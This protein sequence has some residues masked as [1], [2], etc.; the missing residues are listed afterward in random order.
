MFGGGTF[1][2]S[3]DDCGDGSHLVV[4]GITCKGVWSR[5]P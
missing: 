3:L 2:F 4:G 1:F 5:I